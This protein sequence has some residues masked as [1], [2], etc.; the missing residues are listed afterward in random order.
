[1][2]HTT[3]RIVITGAPGTGKT[4]LMQLLKDEGY[5]VHPEMA[6]QLIREQQ[7]NDGTALP[8]KDHRTFGR[9]LF[10]RQVGQYRGALEGQVNF[11]DRGIPDNL[12]Y[13]RRDGLPAPDLERQARKYPY[14]PKVFLT[15]PWKDIYDQDAER[16]EDFELMLAIDAALRAIYFEY[17]YQII[18]VPRMAAEDRL[19]FVLYHL[20][21]HLTDESTAK[22]T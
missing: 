22:N 17:G 13:L 6:R 14:F 19:D 10:Q 16:W 2:S 1:M 12:A 8:W 5:A 11:F 4:T 9:E 20:R 3:Q 7:A 18:E 21:G 15:P